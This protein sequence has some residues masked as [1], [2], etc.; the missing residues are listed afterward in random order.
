VAPHGRQGGIHYGIPDTSH[1]PGVPAAAQPAG[2]SAQLG[3]HLST[4][5]FCAA[6]HVR[7]PAAI[8]SSRIF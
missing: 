7:R 8:D 1:R 4:E 6:T 5:L 3:L 2:E